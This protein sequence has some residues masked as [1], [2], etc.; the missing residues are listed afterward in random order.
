MSHPF[1]E[2]E[3]SRAVRAEKDARVNRWQILLPVLTLT[4]S[5]ALCLYGFVIYFIH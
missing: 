2:I 4:V 3:I 5:T 1:A